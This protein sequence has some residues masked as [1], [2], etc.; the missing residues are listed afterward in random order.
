V[1]GKFGAVEDLFQGGSA[2]H[3]EFILSARKNKRKV[4]RW[5]FFTYTVKSEGFSRRSVCP[6]Y[7]LLFSAAAKAHSCS[8]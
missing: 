1:G 3:G 8:L 7:Y 4:D 6:R 5:G 2:V